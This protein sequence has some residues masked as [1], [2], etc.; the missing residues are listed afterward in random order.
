MKKMI[1]ICLLIVSVAFVF[2]SCTTGGADSEIVLDQNDPTAVKDGSVFAPNSV[3]KFAWTNSNGLS[4]P[5]DFTLERDGVVVEQLHE[6]REV[7]TSVREEGHYIAFIIPAA[8]SD[9]RGIKTVQ[10]SVNKLYGELYNSSHGLYFKDDVSDLFKQFSEKG[11][12]KAGIIFFRLGE[13]KIEGT[14]ET[15]NTSEALNLID[16]DEDGLYD[17][18]EVNPP[19]GQIWYE[20]STGE[21]ESARGLA[22]YEYFLYGKDS[23]KLVASIVDG[24]HTG[25][26][27]TIPWAEV[28]LE[29]NRPYTRL[30]SGAG[31]GMDYGKIVKISERYDSDTVPEFSLMKESAATQKGGASITVDVVAPNAADFA[32]LYNTKYMQVS[33]SYPANLT[34]AGVEFDNYVKEKNEVCSYKVLE[35]AGEKVVVLYRGLFEGMDEEVE[36]SDCFAKLTFDTSEETGAGQIKLTYDET[37]KLLYGPLFRNDKNE[38]VDGFVINY[39]PIEIA[40]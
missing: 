21:F 2:V 38:N 16:T 28:G 32:T 22:R 13:K 10:F 6:V 8:A 33:V 25:D 20:F 24:P 23:I 37:G 26:T 5:C 39:E 34:L 11:R 19:Y 12:E 7:I 17:T 27:I 4:V 14:N 18:W 30:I 1:F 15:I 36:I 29:I 9:S 3:V 35:T 31:A 40:W